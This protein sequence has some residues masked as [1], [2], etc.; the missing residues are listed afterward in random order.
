MSADTQRPPPSQRA[1]RDVLL[2]AV[3]PGP[4]PPRAL[5]SQQERVRARTPSAVRRISVGASSAPARAVLPEVRVVSIVAGPL[6]RRLRAAELGDMAAHVILE[7]DVDKAAYLALREMGAAGFVAAYD[8]ED[9]SDLHALVTKMRMGPNMLPGLVLGAA[10]LPPRE[11]FQLGIDSALATHPRHVLEAI[12]QF[13]TDAHAQTSGWLGTCDK[14]AAAQGLSPREAEVGLP[15]GA[16]PLRQREPRPRHGRSQ[17][18]RH[19]PAQAHGG[20]A[21][22]EVGPWVWADHHRSR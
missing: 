10:R 9:L 22:R 6:A 19:R 7:A 21:R 8:P 16:R 12:V 14:L 5:A 2:G 11:R 20:Q 17:R 3:A 4:A 13:A 18:H 15:N 1:S